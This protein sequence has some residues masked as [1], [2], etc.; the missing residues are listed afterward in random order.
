MGPGRSR[1]GRATAPL[2]R[3]LAGL[4]AAVLI[5]LGLL[6]V[7][8]L[9]ANP[10]DNA[11]LALWLAA[12]LLWSAAPPF[13]LAVVLPGG[14]V[15]RVVVKVGLTALGVA[16]AAS[17]VLLGWSLLVIPPQDYAYDARVLRHHVLGLAALLLGLGGLG[18]LLVRSLRA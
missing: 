1:R 13:A 15:R 12:L 10:S 7:R 5:A 8:L 6:F 17:A 2:G 4:S 14:G 18:V 3:G 16:G 9:V 11:Y